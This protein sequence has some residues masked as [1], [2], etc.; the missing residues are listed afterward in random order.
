MLGYFLGKQDKGEKKIEADITNQF[1]IK[2]KT[3]FC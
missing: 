1:N 3:K 2:L